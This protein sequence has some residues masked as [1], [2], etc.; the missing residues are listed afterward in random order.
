MTGSILSR[1][2]EWDRK[3]FLTL[4][5]SAHLP[6]DDLYFLLY[7]LHTSNGTISANNRTNRIWEEMFS[8]RRWRENPMAKTHNIRYKQLLCGP[9]TLSP[10]ESSE[11]KRTPP[12]KSFGGMLKALHSL[13]PLCPQ[14][15]SVLHYPQLLCHM[16]NSKTV[17][18]LPKKLCQKHNV[19]N[20]IFPT[21]F[22]TLFTLT[23]KNCFCCCAQQDW[24]MT[25]LE[26]TSR[27]SF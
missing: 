2:W 4:A 7:L 20:S 27:P 22:L 13:G 14:V 15:T 18:H 10:S 26:T 9:T 19:T 21:T 3:P 5:P 23:K 8:L 16:P 6:T 11:S 24:F 25:Q 1:Y 12:S 17:D